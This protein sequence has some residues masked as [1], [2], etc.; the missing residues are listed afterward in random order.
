M[1]ELVN[2]KDNS[3]VP[4]VSTKKDVYLLTNTGSES[5]ITS[6]TKYY[7][8][9]KLK[10]EVE[11][12][13]KKIMVDGIEVP[14][15]EMIAKSSEFEDT[16]LKVVLFINRVGVDHPEVQRLMDAFE[17]DGA[18]DLA[19]KYANYILSKTRQE[20]LYGLIE[21]YDTDGTTKIYDKIVGIDRN[22]KKLGAINPE[23]F[24]VINNSTF[25]VGIKAGRA[26]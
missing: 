5:E 23:G 6:M 3:D 14:I 1:S 10:A 21:A 17:A 12:S 4:Y 13:D 9:L 11:S 25:K 19:S 7:E 22:G 24:K 18:F 15:K 26:T 8:Y 16:R 2:S 20:K